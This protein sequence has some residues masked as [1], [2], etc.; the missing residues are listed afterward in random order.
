WSNDQNLVWR[1]EMPG[2]GS[3]CPITFGNRI[4]VTAYSGYGLDAE[5]PGGI[6]DLGLHVGCLDRKDGTIVWDRPIPA[7]NAQ[8]YEGQVINDGYATPTPVT[9]G[10]GVYSFF[11]SSGVVSHDF[12]GNE[13]WRASAGTKTTGFGS[14]ASPILHGDLLIV[15]ASIEST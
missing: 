14:A 7:S 10:K 9:D 5:T 4:F 8:A 6:E 12:E 15:N 13:L 2:F 11:G 3:S 1:S